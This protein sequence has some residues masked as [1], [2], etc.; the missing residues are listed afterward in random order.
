MYGMR[1]IALEV[2]SRQH[3][4]LVGFIAMLSATLLH[5]IVILPPCQSL[6]KHHVEA[7]RP[8]ITRLVH[9]ISEQLVYQLPGQHMCIEYPHAET[10]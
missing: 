9:C 5:R 2:V 6:L 1:K 4:V 8:W 3:N 7:L 10:E